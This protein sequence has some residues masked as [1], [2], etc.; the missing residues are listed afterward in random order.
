[1]Y[2]INGQYYFEWNSFYSLS[3]IALQK[4]LQMATAKGLR[5]LKGGP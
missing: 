5:D 3:F 4:M 1:M 2:Q